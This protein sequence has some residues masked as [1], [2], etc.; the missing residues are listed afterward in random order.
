MYKFEHV[1]TS[2]FFPLLESIFWEIML[3]LF[4]V[5][6]SYF[7]LFK[8]IWK[9]GLKLA[10]VKAIS[11]LYYKWKGRVFDYFF[12]VCVMVLLLLIPNRYICS[13]LGKQKQRIIGP[14]KKIKQFD[15]LYHPKYIG[16]GFRNVFRT[17]LAICDYGLYFKY[18][19]LAGVWNYTHKKC[20]WVHM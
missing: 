18:K 10:A 11:T 3:W 7:P 12:F 6:Y 20:Q 2:F 14:L 17:L 19:F 8:D 5:I 4:G 16:K 9:V 15:K 1:S 13:E